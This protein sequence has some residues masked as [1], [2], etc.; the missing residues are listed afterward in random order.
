M[1]NEQTVSVLY[2][3]PPSFYQNYTNENLK[4]REDA[5]KAASSAT[6]AATIQ[7]QDFSFLDPPK[8]LTSGTF[9]VFGIEKPV[10]FFFFF[11]FNK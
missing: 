1:S 5:M 3:P 4:L 9:V 11:Y 6:L 10:N 7:Q 8:P 2:P